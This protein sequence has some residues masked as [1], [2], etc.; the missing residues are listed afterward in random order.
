MFALLCPRLN[1]H[2][3]WHSLDGATVYC[4]SVHRAVNKKCWDQII[5]STVL[6]RL[7]WHRAVL[8]VAGWYG[9]V[10]A[11]KAIQSSLEECPV[12]ALGL[13]CALIQLLILSLYQLFVWLLYF[14]PYLFTSLRIGRFCFQARCCKRRPNLALVFLCIFHVFVYFVM[15]AF[16]CCC[17][18]FIFSVL[19]Q[20][21]GCEEHLKND[22]FCV[23]VNSIN[24]HRRLPYLISET[25]YEEGGLPQPHT[26][27]QTAVPHQWDRLQAV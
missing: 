19:S 22:L 25:I 1:V 8:S 21:I 9:L 27:I 15:D 17:D 16:C 26:T 14:L 7:C 6:L 11:V 12:Q 24:Q 10:L 5:W 3:L 13:Y 23:F 4:M 20:E 2:V 18:R